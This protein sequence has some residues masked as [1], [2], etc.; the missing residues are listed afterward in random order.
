MNLR[1]GITHCGGVFIFR[2]LILHA[3]VALA[4]VGCE[5]DAPKSNTHS[6]GSS[7]PDSNSDSH[8]G[9]NIRGKVKVDRTVGVDVDVDTR[10]GVRVKVDTDT[11]MNNSS[12]T[13][14]KGGAMKVLEK[15]DM[16]SGAFE[17][18]QRIPTKFT[19]EGEDMSPPISWTVVPE[20]TKEF[21][22]IVDDPDAPI[23]EPFVHWVIYKIPVD[24]RDL[25]QDIPDTERVSSPHGALQGRNSFGSIGYRGPMPPR[26]HGLHHYRFRLYALDEEL[27]LKPGMDKKALLAAIKDH[28]IAEGEIVGTYQR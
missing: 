6:N 10:N 12:K 13:R 1:Q 3:I 19:G 21:A 11:N 25:P 22:L 26:G 4:I 17:N 5:K 28:V 18:G 20:Q 7:S 27:D 14:N 2:L 24:V 23:A 15:I 16:M 8:D 9:V